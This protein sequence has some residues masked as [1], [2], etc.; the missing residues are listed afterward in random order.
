[1]LN[2]NQLVGLIQDA[3]KED[4]IKRASVFHDGYTAL[5]SVVS[6]INRDTLVYNGKF[7]V[8]VSLSEWGALYNIA[9]KNR[10]GPLYCLCID[11]YGDYQRIWIKLV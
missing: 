9:R 7:E 11:V 1:M 8:K 10:A 6:R 3:A 2:R 5:R 4:V